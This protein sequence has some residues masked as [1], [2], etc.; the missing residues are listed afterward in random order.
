MAGISYPDES[1]KVCFE[2]MA[3]EGLVGRADGLCARL[4]RCREN[5]ESKIKQDKAFVYL[6]LIQDRL[7]SSKVLRDVSGM[8]CPTT[9]YFSGRC[10]SLFPVVFR[11]K[12]TATGSGQS[13]PSAG[14]AG[15]SVRATKGRGPVR[16]R[17]AHWHLGQTSNNNPLCFAALCF[18]SVPRD[19]VPSRGP[20]FTMP[21]AH[22]HATGPPPPVGVFV[23]VPT[24]FKPQA[25]SKS[26]RQVEVDVA[27]Q[28][29]HSVH[30]A[31]A[32][33]RGLVLLG[34][35]GEAIHMS[36]TERKALLAGVR[37]GLT[38]A[39]FPDYPIMAGVLTNSVDDALEQLHHA[40]ESGAQWGLVLAPGYFG[41]AVNQQNIKEWY[42]DVA[43]ESPLPIL[44]YALLDCEA[45]FVT[46]S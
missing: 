45:C 1:L 4:S 25:D 22:A 2:A 42:T 6:E 14:M 28:V 24:F 12:L 19:F 9:A 18:W 40:K 5:L 35:T 20:V 39:G 44:T 26:S 11:E 41:L 10:L 37:K 27:T 36:S 34:S 33:I 15:Y 21:F 8:A 29:Q 43:N 7:L 16:H 31:E 32:G 13:T 30:L 17:S 23:P 46:D 3:V 38:D